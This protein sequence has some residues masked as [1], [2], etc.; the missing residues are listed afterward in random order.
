MLVAVSWDG[1]QRKT[2]SADYDYPV[3]RMPT[4]RTERTLERMMGVWLL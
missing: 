1:Y 3:Y 4:G 2:Y